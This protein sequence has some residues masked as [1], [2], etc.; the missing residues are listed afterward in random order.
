MRQFAAPSK[1]KIAFLWVVLASLIALALALRIAFGSALGA[2]AVLGALMLAVGTAVIF[3]ANFKLAQRHMSM[4][5]D[6]GQRAMSICAAFASL[7]AY[8][9]AVRQHERRSELRFQQ[10]MTTADQ[11]YEAKL[12]LQDPGLPRI[13]LEFAIRSGGEPGASDSPTP[14]AASAAAS[15]SPLQ[16]AGPATGAAAGV[17]GEPGAGDKP[18]DVGPVDAGAPVKP[19]PKGPAAAY[20]SARGWG[21]RLRPST[22]MQYSNGADHGAA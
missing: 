17:A 13:P 2:A 16:D 21:L 9:A 1:A 12:E 22:P 11:C 6:R 7:E 19:A 20:F 4:A 8:E 3:A 5:G 10:V 14:D 18:R 15:Y